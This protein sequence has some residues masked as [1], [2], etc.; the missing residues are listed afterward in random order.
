[1]TFTDS[2]TGGNAQLS[3]Q[4]TVS[5]SDGADAWGGSIFIQSRLK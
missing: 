3:A 1:M 4:Q 5:G 2:N